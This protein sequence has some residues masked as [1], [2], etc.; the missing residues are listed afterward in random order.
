MKIGL[1]GP[2]YQ[3]RS[4]PF[5][6]QRTINLYPELDEYGKEPASLFSIPGKSLFATAGAGPIRGSFESANGRAFFVSG[7]NLYEVDVNG[8]ETLLGSLLGSTG[9]VSMAEG[10]TQLAICDE[11][12]LYY[13]EYSSNTFAKVSDPD[14][15]ASVGFVT[16]IDGYFVVNEN[17]SGRF[18][19][20][21]LNDV[22][23]WDALDF[24]T[25]ESSPDNLL[26]CINAV[27]QLWLFGSKT[28]EI[29]TN[30]GASSF[31]F[32]RISGAV[33]EQGILAR[34]TAIELENSVFWVGSDDF[35]NGVVYRAN[36]FIP[37]RI[38][39]T[40]IEKRIQE[41]SNTDKLSAYAYQEDGHIFYVIT[42]GGLETSLVYDLTTQ[43]WHERGFF[44]DD[45]NFE[46]DLAANHIFAFGK[47]LVGDRRNG[48]IYEQS[49]N[50]YTDAGE[51]IVRDR[52]YT[53]ISDEDKRL[54]FNSLDLGVETGVGLQ[55]GQG[56]D[57][58]ISMRLSKDGART[59]TN[60][61]TTSIGKVG[62]YNTKV[63]FRRL[64]ISEQ[65]TIN[66]RYTEPTKF[67][68]TGSYLF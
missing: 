15:P 39:T 34:H 3:Q 13:L 27:G 4:L 45:G 1:V 38:S 26:C 10:N 48:N 7:T 36:G 68:I 32:A 43:L 6:A 17:N 18:Y 46:Q 54:R 23:S 52:I 44:N 55:S 40:P 65:L 2:S 49:L 56:S 31:P 33:M 5:D 37:Q 57:P 47:H 64:G 20:S 60:W 29:W 9:T 25:A 8:S 66:I 63:S 16:N 21:A 61:E 58:L 62:Q 14:L 42:G 53:H 22:T 12:N 30:T 50:F 24:A 41:S 11:T 19:I 67:A 51:E 28:T 59:W 35:G